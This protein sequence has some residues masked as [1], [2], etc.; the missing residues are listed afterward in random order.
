MSKSKRITVSGR[1]LQFL[2][3]LSRDMDESNLTEALSY[4]L[5]DIRLLNYQIGNKPAQQPQQAQTPIGYAF[6]PATFEPAFVPNIDGD[7]HERNHIEIDPIISRMASLIEE[8]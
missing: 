6:D 7:R 3:Q 8:F 4:L 5:A 1:N 2:Q